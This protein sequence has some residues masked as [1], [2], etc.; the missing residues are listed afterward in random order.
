MK[1]GI[2]DQFVALIKETLK[3]VSYVYII[4]RLL[5]KSH[6]KLA[7]FVYVVYPALSKNHFFSFVTSFLR[8]YD[9]SQIPGKKNLHSNTKINNTKEISAIYYF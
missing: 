2:N 8:K 6:F 5:V 1:N 9:L 3:Q 4:K 7:F